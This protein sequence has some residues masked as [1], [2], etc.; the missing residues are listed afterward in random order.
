MDFYDF[1]GIPLAAAAIGQTLFVLFYLTFPWWRSFLGRALFFKASAFAALLN[2]IVVGYLWDWRH[3]QTA[4]FVLYVVLAVGVWAQVVAFI[5][6]RRTRDQ[7]PPVSR[8][9]ADL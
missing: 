5:A 4:Y 9:E 2:T 3:E 8:N 6:T 1:R 7:D